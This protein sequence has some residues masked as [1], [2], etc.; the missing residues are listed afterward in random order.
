MSDVLS[1]C[2]PCRKIEVVNVPGSEGLDG[3]DGTNG[4]DA[5]TRTTADFVVPNDGVT[6]GPIPVENSTW[7]VIGQ[8]VIVG[9]GWDG[10][11]NGPAHFKVA[12]IPSSTS[13]NLTKLTNIDDLP[14]LSP[15]GSGSTVSPSA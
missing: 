13:V 14:M 6:L 15:I 1:C 12:A 11:G 2:T 5:F 4:V 10:V 9:V 3:T 8:V 7:M